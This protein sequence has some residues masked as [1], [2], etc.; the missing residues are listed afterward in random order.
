MYCVDICVYGCQKNT[1]TLKWFTE[2]L[3]FPLTGYI[4]EFEIIDDHR[5]GKIVVNLKGR[6]N[7]VYFSLEIKC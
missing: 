1:P 3:F 6:I 5:A 4:D 7:K 2:I